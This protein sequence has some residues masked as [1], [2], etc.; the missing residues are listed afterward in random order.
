MKLIKTQKNIGLIR[1]FNVILNDIKL[2]SFEYKN[3]KTITCNIFSKTTL[4][5]FRFGE[6]ENR[7]TSTV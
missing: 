3:L 5:F 7:S 2:S 6:T 4:L 1:G